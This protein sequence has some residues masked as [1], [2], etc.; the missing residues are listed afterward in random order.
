[1]LVDVSGA[2]RSK[3]HLIVA[4]G[5]AKVFEIATH[6]P[7][8]AGKRQKVNAPA[9]FANV[10]GLGEREGWPVALQSLPDRVAAWVGPSPCDWPKRA[11]WS[12]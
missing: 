4:T 11:P 12:R 7:G 5:L 2:L 6:L 10:I 8:E 1:M 3:G 9:G